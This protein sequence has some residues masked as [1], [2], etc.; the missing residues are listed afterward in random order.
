MNDAYAHVMQVQRDKLGV[1]TLPPYK[2]L[3][4]RFGKR[5]V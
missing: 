5:T 1:T 2:N 4:P 3:I